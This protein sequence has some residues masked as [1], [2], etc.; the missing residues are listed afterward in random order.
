MWGPHIKRPVRK[1]RSSESVPFQVRVPP[2]PLLQSHAL[3]SG[4]EVAIGM[5]ALVSEWGFGDGGWGMGDWE[6]K[7][8]ASDVENS[9]GVRNDK[10]DKFKGWQRHGFKT[11]R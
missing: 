4:V 1:W 5:K 11:L 2:V 7:D 8:G 6:S 3:S 9:K 10:E